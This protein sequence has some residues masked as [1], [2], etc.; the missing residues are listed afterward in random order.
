MPRYISTAVV[1]DVSLTGETL[2]MDW[3]HSP[4]ASRQHYTTSLNMEFIGEKQK[5]TTEKHMAPRSGSGRQRNWLHLETV[6]EVGSGPESLG[7][8]VGGLCPRRGDEGFD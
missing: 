2:E 5:R 6:G 3:S 4:Q 8:H 1:Q 7:S